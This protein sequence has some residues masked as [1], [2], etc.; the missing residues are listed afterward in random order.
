MKTVK[1]GEEASHFKIGELA[2]DLGNFPLAVRHLELAALKN[3]TIEVQRALLNAMVESNTG[4][5]AANQGAHA[6]GLF[7]KDP[8][9]ELSYA[10]AL[11]RVDKNIYAYEHLFKFINH[12]IAPHAGIT[13]EMLFGRP[14]LEEKA[15]RVNIGQVQVQ[16]I[17]G[18][19]KEVTE[20]C[21]TSGV[22]YFVV[23]LLA[24]RRNI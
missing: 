23:Y 17:S 16:V 3:P 1:F 21:L 15:H 12:V 6:H 13:M 4:S 20:V 22:V 5:R 9:L 24:M 7:P 2:V 14:D 19:T 18:K 11:A 8:T 10:A